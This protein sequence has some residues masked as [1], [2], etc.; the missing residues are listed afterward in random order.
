M[1]SKL[2]PFSP[3]PF[4]LL[5]L[6]AATTVF[7][8]TSKGSLSGTILDSSG[9]AI[10]NAQITA[11][12]TQSGE[13]R[14]T[15]SGGDGQYRVEAIPPSVYTITVSAAGFSRKEVSGINVQASLVTAQNVTLDVGATEQTISVEAAVAQLQTESGDLSSTISA[16]EIAKLPINSLNPIDLVLTQPGVV[17]VEGRDSFTNGSGFSANGLRPRANNFLIDGFDNNDQAI[18]GQALQPGNLEAIKEV[19]VLRNSY[20]PEFGRG[21]ASVTNVIYKNG[22]N[23]LHGSLWERYTGSGLN[24]LTSEEKRSGLTAK[25][26]NV[27]NTFGFAAGAPIIKNKLFL[28]GSSQWH[29]IYGAETGNQLNIPTAQGVANLKAIAGLYPNAGILVDSLGGLAAQTQTG[30]INVGTRA[31]CGT[32]G[33]PC[34]IPIGHLVRATTQ[35]NPSYEFVVRGDYQ[36][37]QKDTISGRYIGTQSTLTPDLFA[38]GSALP[39]QDTFQGGPARNLGSFWTHVFSPAAV[40]EARFTFQ[41]I[42][43]QFGLLSSAP[44]SLGPALTVAGLSGTTF[45]GVPSGFPQG[46]GHNTFGYQDAVSLTR[47]NHSFKVGA[48]INHLQI[49]DS[50][51]FNSRGTISYV[52]GGNCPAISLTTC[53]GLANFLDDFTG[54]SGTAGRQFGSSQVNFTQTTQAYYIQ[55][56]WKIRPTLTMTYGVRYEYFSTPFN[57][58]KYP[59]VNLATVLTDPFPTAVKQRPDRNNWGPRIGLAYNPGAGKTVY[60]AGAGVFYDGF[61]TNIQDNVASSAPNTLGGTITAPGSGRGLAA[62]SGLVPA[63]TA[64]LN[65]RASLSV[66]DAHIVSPMTYQWNA[67]MERQLPGD[68][69]LTLAYVGTRANRLFI[70]RELN[71]GVNGVRL[72]PTRGAIG[73]RT[74]A[75]DSSYHGLQTDL[76]RKFKNGLFFEAAYT[77]SHAIDVGSEVFTTTGGSSF[78][79]DPFNT[80]GERGPSAFDRRHRGSLT[81]VYT[82]PFRANGGAGYRNALNYAV[83][84][85]T[86]SGTAQLQSGA[87]D[88][89]HL[90]GFDENGDLRST[91]DRPDSG[92]PSAPL[93]YSDACLNS[94]TCITGVGQLQ[95]NGSLLDFNTGAAGTPNQFRYVVVKGRTG[96]A[97]RNTLVNDWTQDYAFSVERLFPIPHLEHHQLEFRAEGINPFNH[98]NPGLV[99]TDLL[100]P[101]FLNRDIQYRGGRILN[102]WLKY[103]F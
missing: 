70:N 26:R 21:G 33:S 54:P 90:A 32:P 61:F 60:R 73:A 64:T 63:V 69:L 96:N 65:P 84:N 47:G 1:K 14:T 42:D 79:Q 53:T 76:S 78:P 68:M 12:D 46:R 6:A 83:R 17:S 57:F 98:P 9:G 95:P 91:N 31:G 52:G 7:G 86:I 55:D 80:R 101:G 11:K 2:F 30:S 97:G 85:W 93:N 13:T 40:N 56:S 77:W 37:T 44:T 41:Q 36:M 92:N 102:L 43:F 29:R 45:G 51:P 94:A 10:A 71:P 28:F 8:Q 16:G 22:T 99:S 50:I 75:G 88:T 15:K 100:D 20:A 24:A 66:I 3:P 89:I 23:E 4:L 62:A 35:Q 18:G 82:S 103:R 59:A 58:L 81:W 74:N 38:N 67:N 72:N 27:D 25:P 39:T 34:L 19:T 49:S 48:D 5:L 87:P